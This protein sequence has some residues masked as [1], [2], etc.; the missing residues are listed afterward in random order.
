MLEALII[1]VVKIGVVFGVLLLVA[2]YMTWVERKVIA[3]IQVRW[4]PTRVGPF[5]LLQPIRRRHQ[6]VLQ[7]RPDPE[8][9]GSDSV[10]LA[11]R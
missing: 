9:G 4:G 6:A 7:G 1:M 3:A 10:L 2:A 11:P 8:P 5:G